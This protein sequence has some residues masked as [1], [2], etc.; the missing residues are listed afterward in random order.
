MKLIALLHLFVFIFPPLDLYKIEFNSLDGQQISMGDYAGKR[1]LVVSV[2]G[3]TASTV[4][5]NYLDSLQTA[6]E[7]IQVIIVPVI[8]DYRRTGK[9]SVTAAK[10]LLKS[11]LIVAE[12]SLVRRN[13]EKYQHPLFQWLTNASNNAHF[14]VDGKPGQYY[15]I[16]SKGTL[17]GVLDQ[18]AP[19]SVLEQAL[20]INFDE[21]QKLLN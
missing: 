6:L 3:P 9:A 5:F 1:I 19:H 10:K 17:Y 11:R 15:L 12:T 14:N 18:G 16:S 8:D 13:A 20:Q 2:D 21:S 7:D 4:Q